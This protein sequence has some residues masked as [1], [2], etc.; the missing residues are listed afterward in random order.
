MTS[1]DPEEWSSSPYICLAGI[2]PILLGVWT[3]QQVIGHF[4]CPSSQS[5]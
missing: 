1:L 4:A 2:E 3:R 5:H